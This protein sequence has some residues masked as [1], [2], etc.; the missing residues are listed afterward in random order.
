ME[1]LPFWMFLHAMDEKFAENEYYQ[2]SMSFVVKFS[3]IVILA[4]FEIFDLFL[5]RC[6]L[7]LQKNSSMT[8]IQLYAEK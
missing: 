4:S 7:T 5:C 8:A 3:R 1:G 2:K 6:N